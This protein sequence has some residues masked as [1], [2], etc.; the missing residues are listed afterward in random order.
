MDEEKKEVKVL[1]INTGSE[2]PKEE[3]GLRITSIEPI[4]EED[5][6]GDDIPEEVKQMMKGNRKLNPLAYEPA[7]EI[8]E[9]ENKKNVMK[10]VLDKM[11]AGYLPVG[12]INVIYMPFDERYDKTNLFWYSQVVAK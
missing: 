8:I 2:I 11:Q 4:T 12:G 9:G 5:L 1:D 7:Y 10:V 6:Q 3:T